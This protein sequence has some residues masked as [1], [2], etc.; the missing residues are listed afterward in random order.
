MLATTVVVLTALQTTMTYGSGDQSYYANFGGVVQV[1]ANQSWGL[2][3]QG[4]W[5]PLRA[6]QT[7]ISPGSAGIIGGSRHQNPGF[8][9]PLSITEN[10]P[11]GGW[12]PSPMSGA[13]NKSSPPHLRP[14]QIDPSGSRVTPT[15][16]FSLFTQPISP[17]F[18]S[19]TSAFQPPTQYPGHLV[20]TVLAQHSKVPPHAHA[21]IAYMWR[22]LHAQQQLA[23][24]LQ[25]TGVP[26]APEWHEALRCSD[27]SQFAPPTDN[28]AE[29]NLA[30]T[31]EARYPHNPP[32]PTKPPTSNA[33]SQTE[34]GPKL[35]AD[36]LERAVSSGHDERDLVTAVALLGPSHSFMQAFRAR[37]TCNTLHLTEEEFGRYCSKTKELRSMIHN[38][39]QRWMTCNVEPNT[40]T[41]GEATAQTFTLN[42]YI[43]DWAIER[44][45]VS[46]QQLTLDTERCNPKPSTRMP[47]Q[48]LSDG[49]LRRLGDSQD[50]KYSHWRSE[51]EKQANTTPKLLTQAMVLMGASHDLLYRLRSKLTGF[52]PAFS[53]QHFNNAAEDAN[54]IKIVMQSLCEST[55]TPEDYDEKVK[56]LTSEI[57]G[58]DLAPVTIKPSETQKLQKAARKKFGCARFEMAPTTQQSPLPPIATC[59]LAPW[60]T[61]M[62]NHSEIEAC[63]PVKLAQ[64][65]PDRLKETSQWAKELMQTE[66]AQGIVAKYNKQGDYL[67]RALTHE[68]FSEFANRILHP[69]IK[70][71]IISGPQLEAT[72]LALSAVKAHNDKQIEP[73]ENPNPPKP[74][75]QRR[76]PSREESH[77]YLDLVTNLRTIAGKFKQAE[78]DFEEAKKD[79]DES[80]QTATKHQMAE[81]VREFLELKDAVP[82]LPTKEVTMSTVGASCAVANTTNYFKMSYM[83]G[84]VNECLESG[85]HEQLQK[86]CGTSTGYVRNRTVTTSNEGH[87]KTLFNEGL[88]SDKEFDALFH[89]HKE[90]MKLEKHPWGDDEGIEMPN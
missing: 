85:N 82:K 64:L 6:E 24:Q 71:Q 50:K 67:E 80:K 4:S 81:I 69:L 27:V 54:H 14:G 16:D 31:V 75:R 56:R 21:H 74:T 79:G 22:Q 57:F 33:S 11:P 29:P 63:K 8:V 20:P 39:Y 41:P 13:S 46:P 58:T 65:N 32:L 55:E 62:L 5:S 49:Q 70:H 44:Y 10:S 48:R 73:S 90:L 47:N 89:Q 2:T 87:L 76:L 77:A 66:R 43:C 60:I 40:Q 23:A 1:D 45:K 7:Q 15:S 83:T 35:D 78:Q 18:Q 42:D 30:V 86:L 28:Q 9:S 38:I 53:A 25:Q 61:C 59:S 72:A 52:I 88:L 84:A 36:F 34:M 26:C 19:Q 3:E 17:R 51:C 12:L 37:M 68:E